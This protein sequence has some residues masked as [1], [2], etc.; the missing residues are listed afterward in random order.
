MMARQPVDYFHRKLGKIM[1]NKKLVWQGNKEGLEE[2]IQ[3]LKH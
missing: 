2:A 3:K 1:W